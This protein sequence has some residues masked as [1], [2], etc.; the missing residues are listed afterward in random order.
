MARRRSDSFLADVA[1]AVLRLS[2]RVPLIGLALA[3]ACGLGW[4]Y[5]RRHP[6][7]FAAGVWS[8]SCGV[9]GLFFALIAVVGFLRNL[10]PEGE[11]GS[12]RRSR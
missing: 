5:F 10:F 12:R 7:V 11:G 4:W 3:L 2:H 9:A 6:E 1:G 8:I